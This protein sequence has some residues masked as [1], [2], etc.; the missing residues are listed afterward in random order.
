MKHTESKIQSAC[1]R[2]FRLQYPE[3]AKLLISVPN[4]VATTATQGRILK[5]EGM[6]AGASDL[7]LLLPNR[8]HPFLCI[9]FKTEKGRQ[10]NAQKDWQTAVQFYALARYAVVRSVEEFISLITDYLSN[11]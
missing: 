4:G 9:E 3:F 5:A 11:Q 7:L 2:W 1:V 6:V 8:N 10:S